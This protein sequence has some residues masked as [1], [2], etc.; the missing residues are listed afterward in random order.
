MFP[1]RGSAT[2]VNKLT[3]PTVALIAVLGTTAVALSSLAH[4]D[5]AA[6]LGAV[7]LLAGIGG[8]AAVSGAVSG[9][10]D[11]LHADT[12]AQTTTLNTIAKRVNGDLDARIAAAMEE[13][14]ETGAARAITAMQQGLPK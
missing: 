11:D 13:A 3:W 2:S 8:G 12:T 7:G 4:W 6:I 9:K 5:A 14:A 10:V 1:G